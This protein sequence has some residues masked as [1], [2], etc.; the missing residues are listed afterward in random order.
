M[1]RLMPCSS[2]NGSYWDYVQGFPIWFGWFIGEMHQWK[3]FHKQNFRFVR[4]NFAQKTNDCFSHR[5]F[6]ATSIVFIA[7]QIQFVSAKYRGWLWGHTRINGRG[8][9][10]FRREKQ[11]IKKAETRWT[12]ELA[13]SRRVTPPVL[14]YFNALS[15][16]ADVLFPI[17]QFVTF[18]QLVDTS[19]RLFPMRN[20]GQW[21]VSVRVRVFPKCFWD[22]EDYFRGVVLSMG[23]CVL[24][25]V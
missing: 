23:C 6:C 7:S 15:C 1:N 11:A 14:L 13:K 21:F 10:P 19:F 4:V 16:P 18:R 2:I 8:H 24:V 5:P 12:S 17:G 9:F 22:V 20:F 25:C 3:K